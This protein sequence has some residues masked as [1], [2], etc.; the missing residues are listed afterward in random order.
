M[1]KN[2]DRNTEL[3][4]NLLTR[5]LDKE[6]MNHDIIIKYFIVIRTALFTSEGI[7]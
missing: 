6:F 2:H 1:P 4:I 5:G 3:I 7:R